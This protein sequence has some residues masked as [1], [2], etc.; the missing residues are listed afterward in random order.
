MNVTGPSESASLD[1]SCF[2]ID[3]HSNSSQK[4]DHIATDN[5]ELSILSFN[6]HGLNSHKMR[7]LSDLFNQYKF[8]TLCETWTSK[9]SDFYLKGYIFEN[10]ARNKKHKLA[11]RYFGGISI[12]IAREISK[13]VV[14]A[15]KRGKV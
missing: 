5:F 12:F 11:W 2:I 6:I 15:V 10:F 1:S 14:I 3:D 9:L 13:G 4:N 8:I 7:L